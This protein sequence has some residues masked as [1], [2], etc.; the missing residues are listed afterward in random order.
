V[1][2]S[3]RVFDGREHWRHLANTVK[4][5]S[6]ADSDSIADDCNGQLVTANTHSTAVLLCPVYD[7][8]AL[9]D[10]AVRPSVRLSP[11]CPIPIT[12]QRYILKPWFLKNTNRKPHAISVG[13]I[14]SPPSGLYIVCNK[15]QSSVCTRQTAC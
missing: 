6:A 2:P 13:H 4:R 15:T 14:V 9:S 3:N 8:W 12:Q 11:V 10:A 1:G 7:R 5:L